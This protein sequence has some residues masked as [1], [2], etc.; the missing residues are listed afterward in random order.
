[1]LD[2]EDMLVEQIVGGI[3]TVRRAWNGTTLSAHS[4]ATVYA[5]RQFSVNRAQLGTT[6]SSWEGGLAVFP[7]PGTAALSTTLAIAEA[8]GQVLQEGSGYARTD[9]RQRRRPHT[10]RRGSHWPIS[11]TRR[12][13]AT[14]EK[15]GCGA[16]DMARVKIIL[17]GPLFDGQAAGAAKDFTDSIANEI[18]QIGRDWI[19]LDT[20]RMTKSGSDTGQAAEGVKMSGGNGAYVISGGIHEEQV[21]TWP[22]LEG[23]SKRNQ[24]ARAS[25]RAISSFSRTTLRMRKQV[26][27]FAQARLEQYLTRG[28]AAARYDQ[29]HRRAGHR[30]VRGHPV[31]RAGTRHLQRRRPA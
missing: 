9:R 8:A 25:T 29:L 2:Q 20:Q 10:R 21:R 11:G 28:W 3:A 18:A 1:M 6:A 12:T 7:A 27:P 16:C 30:T 4:G 17:T 15:P 5:F 24:S 26:T 19:R 31:V 14:A 22:W 23:T 13:P